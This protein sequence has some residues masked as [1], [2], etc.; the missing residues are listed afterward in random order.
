MTVAGCRRS[1]SP[2]IEGGWYPNLQRSLSNLLASSDPARETSGIITSVNLK[3]MTTPECDKR[4]STQLG[5]TYRYVRRCTSGST[6]QNTQ[7]MYTSTYSIIGLRTP[8]GMTGLVSLLGQCSLN[9]N[10]ITADWELHRIT[11]VPGVAH[12]DEIQFVFGMPLRFPDQFT[13]QEI[14][15]SKKMMK[16]W[17]SFMKDGFVHV[18]FG[19][20]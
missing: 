11:Y 1:A 2:I 14:E 16:I 5:T 20:Q 18:S 8:I 17:I 4:S 9:H 10:Q 19:T 6:W 7:T 13:P 3:T 12:F 15:L